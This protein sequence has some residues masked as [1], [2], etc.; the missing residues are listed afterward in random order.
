MPSD[1]EGRPDSDA[2]FE[3]ALAEIL[4]AQ[5]RGSLQD[6]AAYADRWPDLVERLLAHFRDRDFFNGWAARFGPLTT[7]PHPDGQTS[8]QSTLDYSARTLTGLS[9]PTIPERF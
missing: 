9:A 1:S 5:E 8:Q 2:R 3:D 4:Q 6:L 7:V